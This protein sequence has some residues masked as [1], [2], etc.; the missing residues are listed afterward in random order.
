MEPKIDHYIIPFFYQIKQK[1]TIKFA[2]S[3]NDKGFW[4]VIPGMAGTARFER[5]LVMGR[6]ESWRSGKALSPAPPR[7]SVHSVFPNTDFR[8]SSSKGFRSLHPRYR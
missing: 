4:A 2:Y 7:Q 6:V 5:E 1:N 3:A 8:S